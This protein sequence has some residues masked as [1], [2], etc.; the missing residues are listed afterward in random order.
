M[1]IGEKDDFESQYMAKFRAMAAPH[2][3]FVE[4]EVDRAG[5]D[6]GLHFTQ[7]KQSG[8]KIVIP[9]LAWFQ[10]KGIM[11]STLS[12]E[13]YSAAEHASVTLEVAHLRFWYINVQPTYLVLYVGSADQFLVID[14]KEWVRLNYGDKIFQL[15]QTTATIKI[16]KKNKLDDHLFSLI[17]QRNLVPALRTALAQ[18]NDSEI[19]R[20]LRDSSIVKWLVVSREAGLECRLV[21]V[22]YMSKMR[23]EAYFESRMSDGTWEKMRSH[24]EY[25]MDTINVVYPFISFEPKRKVIACERVVMDDDDDSAVQSVVTDLSFAESDDDEFF[26]E[27]EYIDGDCLMEIGDGV[28]SYAESLQ[29]EHMIHELRIELNEVGQRWAEILK[30]LETAEVISVST[31]P[32]FI[33]V[34]PWHG[35]DV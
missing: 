11:S 14:I 15:N 25:L 6:I 35:R 23:T 24:W 20:F 3:I 5:R 17:M 8:G 12:S 29:G 10:M 13:E 27:D 30:V 9:S 1:K 16:S 26:G 18:E 22:K 28:Y 21:V 4:Y 7:P 19:H 34:A 33:D 32:H 31:E 2:G